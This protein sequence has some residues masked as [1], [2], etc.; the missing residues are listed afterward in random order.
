[1]LF[2]ILTLEERCNCSLDIY[3]ILDDLNIK[4]VILKIEKI[5][6]NESFDLFVVYVLYIV[7]LNYG[8]YNT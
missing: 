6:L 3:S 4:L 2:G 7:V 1:M 8:L 5:N